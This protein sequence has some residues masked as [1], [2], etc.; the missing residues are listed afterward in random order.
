MTV[1]VAVTVDDGLVFAAD[2]AASLLATDPN[3]QSF[4]SNVYQH[5]NKVYNLCRGLPV[6]AMTSGM[7]S[8]GRAPIQSLAKDLRLLLKEGSSLA[9]DPSSYIVEQIAINARKFLYEEKFLAL[10]PPP[11][12]PHLLDFW[13][14][15][16][17]SGSEQPELWK[18][19]ILNGQCT[20]PEQIR[21]PGQFGINWGGQPDPVHRLIKGFSQDIGTALIG[22]GL[23]PQQLP[24]L[25]QV[26]SAQTEAPLCHPAMPIQDAIELANFL[27][28]LTKNY[29]RFMPGADVVG[30]ETDIASVTRHEKFKWIKRKHYYP[31][32]LNLLEHDHV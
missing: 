2:S 12:A 21:P 29:F 11:P 16:F 23:D 5:G 7:A 15:G 14:G 20:A 27:V 24:Q 19:T 13:I 25:V 8:I 17:S 4:V 30:G 28:D 3:G 31:A 18:V 1:C 22:A 6:V 10:Q 32:H 9:I 26:I